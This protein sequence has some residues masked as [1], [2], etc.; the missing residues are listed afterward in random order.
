[1]D[2]VD[3][4]ILSM[5]DSGAIE[6][7]GAYNVTNNVIVRLISSSQ[8]AVTEITVSSDKNGA[9]HVVR[10]CIYYGRKDVESSSRITSQTERV[11]LNNILNTLRGVEPEIALRAY[12]QAIDSGDYLIEVYR[13]GCHVVYLRSGFSSS[14][15]G[16][17]DNLRSLMFHMA[18][19]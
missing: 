3:K 7:L 1:M 4:R 6:P 12:H 14:F 5:F 2:A 10:R 15:P 18:W 19:R 11:H 16:D 17:L 9:M 8:I 13:N